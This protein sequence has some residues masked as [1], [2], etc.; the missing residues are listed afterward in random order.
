MDIKKVILKDKDIAFMIND[1]SEESI[2]DRA[3]LALN[4][5]VKMI[6]FYNKTLGDKQNLKIA[7]KL[8]QLCSLFGALFIVLS[9]VDIAE[10]SQ[11][12]GICLFEHDFNLSDTKKILHEDKLFGMYVYT[13]DN[14]ITAK[15]NQFDFVIIEKNIEA[16][17]CDKLN[18]LIDTKIIRLARII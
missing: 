14:I 6:L 2:L 11:S 4:K 16:T 13:K 8:R 9:R 7:K 15:E 3:G 10:L 17:I 5:G 18:E 12:D 1:L